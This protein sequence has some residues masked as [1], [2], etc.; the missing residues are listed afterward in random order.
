[1]ASMFANFVTAFAGSASVTSVI[2]AAGAGSGVRE[3]SLYASRR[4]RVSASWENV[5]SSRSVRTWVNMGESMRSDVSSR[6]RRS[7]GDVV[8][9]VDGDA[10]GEGKEG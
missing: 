4:S 1:M 10:G 6:R 5:A 9:G 2:L 7:A 3:G 8:A